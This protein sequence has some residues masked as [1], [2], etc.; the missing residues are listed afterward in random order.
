[1]DKILPRIIA[2]FVISYICLYAAT[3][4]ILA[5]LQDQMTGLFRHFIIIIAAGISAS[6]F[7]ERTGR[8]PS[9]TEKLCLVEICL[10]VV[11]VVDFAAN[12]FFQIKA[13]S[14]IGYFLNAL[15]LWFAFGS[16]LRKVL[17]KIRG[18]NKQPR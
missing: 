8:L 13:Q 7:A 10:L 12:H 5:L 15:I 18:N 2:L 3:A 4:A 11:I 17:T 1:M 6:I 9:L 14:V 16:I